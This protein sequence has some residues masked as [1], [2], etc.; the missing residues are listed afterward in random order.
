MTDL[1]QR[2]RHTFGTLFTIVGADPGDQD[3]RNVQYETRLAAGELA[4]LKSPEGS[5]TQPTAIPSSIA[6]HGV[7][8]KDRIIQL[9]N[10]G[11]SL[12]HDL[13]GDALEDREQDDDVLHITIDSMRATVLLGCVKALC[14]WSQHPE[15]TSDTALTHCALFLPEYL[16]ATKVDKTEVSIRVLIAQ[17]LIKLLNE[18]HV[19]DRWIKFASHWMTRDLLQ[20]DTFCDNVLAWL[21]D[22]QVK[23]ALSD[24]EAAWV[25]RA[26]ISAPITIL[27][28]LALCIAK[29][30]LLGWS[31]SSEAGDF[32][33]SGESGESGNCFEFVNC[34]LT[35]VST[36]CK[37]LLRSL[38]TL[39]RLA[40]RNLRVLTT[41]GPSPV[42]CP[43][44]QKAQ[45]TLH[46]LKKA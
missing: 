17:G 40:R 22:D 28:Q 4:L 16:A 14:D 44:T 24:S 18:E 11:V 27:S 36:Q 37:L 10:F 30:W 38:L 20:N 35:K 33:N 41:Q 31:L 5:S 26:T 15:F 39:V 6:G 13:I 9:S 1:E 34:Y 42:K 21:Q 2:L 43:W 45:S 46:T 7:T 25:R 19:I 8:I 32:S 29:K 12:G 23:Q 3:S